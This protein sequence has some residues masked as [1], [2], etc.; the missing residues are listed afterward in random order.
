MREVRLKEN[1]VVP[2]KSIRLGRL[3]LSNQNVAERFRLKYSDGS[4]F[5]PSSCLGA[6]SDI[7]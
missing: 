2:T 7:S 1:A 4:I 3:F 5:M 6:F